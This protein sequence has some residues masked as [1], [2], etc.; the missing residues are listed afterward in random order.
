MRVLTCVAA[1]ILDRDPGHGDNI[2]TSC[3][4]ENRSFH[5]KSAMMDK[6]KTIIFYNDLAALAA[7]RRVDSCASSPAGAVWPLRRV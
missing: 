2:E 1:D 4:K 3:V 7:A 6:H 5:L